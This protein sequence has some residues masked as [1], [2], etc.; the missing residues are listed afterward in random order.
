[1]TSVYRSQI[2]LHFSRCETLEPISFTDSQ[3]D[4]VFIHFPFKTFFK[5][6]DGCVYSVFQLQLITVSVIR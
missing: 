2:I 4:V 3:L 1:M 5:S 6:Q